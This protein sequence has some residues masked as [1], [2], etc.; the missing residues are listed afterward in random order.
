MARSPTRHAFVL[1]VVDLDESVVPVAAHE[2]ALTAQQVE[3]GGILVGV[4]LVRVE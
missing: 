2:L 4:Q 1:E 3:R